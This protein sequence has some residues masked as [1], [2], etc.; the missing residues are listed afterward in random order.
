MHGMARHLGG[1]I[2]SEQFTIKFPTWLPAI[3]LIG[4]AAV[5]WMGLK[6]NF[7]LYTLLVAMTVLSLLLSLVVLVARK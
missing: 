2:T 6:W 5:P 1:K 3:F 7:S 4:A